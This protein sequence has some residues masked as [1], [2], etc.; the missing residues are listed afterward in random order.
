MTISAG[1]KGDKR[2]PKS[3]EQ[4]HLDSEYER[5]FGNTVQA[6]RYKEDPD[7]KL[8]PINDWYRLYYKPKPK[9]HY[10]IGDI[11]PYLS[12][13]DHRVINSRK[14]NRDD[15][16]R[17]NT[18]QWEGREAEEKEAARFQAQEEVDFEANL[19]DVVEETFHDIKENRVEVDRSGKPLS[20]TFGM[21]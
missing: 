8:I 16:A 15:H 14:D 18:R 4:E 9:T 19:G 2:R 11:E 10:I 7:G 3:V 5:L 6:G 12:P 20:W 1:G 13:I 21:D 17:N